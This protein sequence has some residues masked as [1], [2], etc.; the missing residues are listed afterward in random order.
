MLVDDLKNNFVDVIA[1]FDGT[2]RIRPLYLKVEGFDA[3][4]IEH[5]LSRGD[6]P[7]TGKGNVLLFQCVY[8]HMGEQRSIMLYYH[9]KDH[10]WTIPGTRDKNGRIC[11]C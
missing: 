10:V 1:I 2:G 3:V 8:D 4:K 7:F 6:A 9:V 5:I 11:V